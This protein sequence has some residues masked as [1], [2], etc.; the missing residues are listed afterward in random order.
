M[1]LI[2]LALAPTCL[3]Q[4]GMR[5]DLARTSMSATSQAILGRREMHRRTAHEDLS[6]H[7]IHFQFANLEDVLGCSADATGGVPQAYAQSCQQPARRNGLVTKSSA[8]AS[9]AAILSNS[10]DR[11]VF[12]SCSLAGGTREKALQILRD[13]HALERA[14]VRTTSIAI[15][16]PDSREQCRC[17]N[18][19]QLPSDLPPVTSQPADLQHCDVGADV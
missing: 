16:H 5:D 17:N 10:W 7:Q 3:Q 18:A 11:A 1:L 12:T 6:S 19:A 4:L 2:E 14:N 15:R 8:P 9:S 13:R